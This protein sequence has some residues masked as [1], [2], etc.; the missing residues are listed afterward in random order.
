[1]CV[2]APHGRL[3][4]RYVFMPKKESMEERRALLEES[5]ELN[6]IGVIES[7][8]NIF[9]NKILL[10]QEDSTKLKACVIS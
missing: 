9:K 1:M 4:M 6:S 5:V 2:K 3:S 8:H 7:N 10:P